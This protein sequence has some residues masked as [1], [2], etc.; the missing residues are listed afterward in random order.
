MQI[1]ITHTMPE[2]GMAGQYPI[3]YHTF[4]A[5]D[6]NKSPVK[7][8]KS[9]KG[10]YLFKVNRCNLLNNNLDFNKIYL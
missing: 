3:P 10:L 2:Y 6:S 1:S 9:D 7:I 5:R 4:P 8:I